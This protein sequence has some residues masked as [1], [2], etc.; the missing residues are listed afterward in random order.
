MGAGW[1]DRKAL[2]LRANE[3]PRIIIRELAGY[4]SPA[5]AGD[6]SAV[7]QFVITDTPHGRWH[8]DIAGGKCEASAG[9]HPSPDLKM[10]MNYRTFSDVALQKTPS[11]S[12]LQRGLLDIE[13]DKHLLA[14]FGRLFPR[15]EF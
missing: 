2:A 13:G 6:R 11:L 4:F 7:I 1:T 12:V 5:A 8:L 10:T 9:L 3:D 15:P 14:E